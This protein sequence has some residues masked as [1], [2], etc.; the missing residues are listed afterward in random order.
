M[1]SPNASFSGSVPLLYDEY[2]GP[3]LFEPYAID[4][5]SRIRKPEP[6]KVLELAC[7]TGRVTHHLG[8]QLRGSHLIATDLNPD[9]IYVAQTR[10]TEGVD[11]W[12]VADMTSL[13]FHHDEFDL[14]VCQYGVMFV[15]DKSVAFK[16]AFR[17]LNQEGTLLFNTWDRIEHNGVPMLTDQVV[18]EY[19]AS[20]PPTFFQTPYSMYDPSQLEKLC[21]EAGFT[22]VTVEQVKKTGYS[23]SAETAA[24]GLIQGSPMIKEIR[25]RNTGAEEAI[26]DIAAKIIS[27]EYGDSPSFPL[28]AW[29]IEA[30]K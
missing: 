9:M 25:E 14:V 28:S 1:N 10:V 6:T 3:M 11:Q 17:V 16:E 12:M 30:S 26:V 19:F 13:P 20:N 7:G 29:V 15:S 27:K 5:V 22:R 8:K 21:M 23:P 2:L 18:R 4:L 24:R